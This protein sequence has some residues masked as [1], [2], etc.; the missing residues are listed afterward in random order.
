MSMTINANI[1]FI[2]F[3]NQLLDDHLLSATVPRSSSV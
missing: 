3:A 2:M 1:I